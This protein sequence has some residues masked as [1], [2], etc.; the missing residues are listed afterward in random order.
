MI[1][2]VARRPILNSELP[3]PSRSQGQSPIE[4]LAAIAADQTRTELRRGGPTH[5]PI[6]SRVVL[7]HSLRT[8][9]PVARRRGLARLRA[10][11]VVWSRNIK[12][13]QST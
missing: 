9:G 3:D 11:R 5:P 10:E 13:L 1:I 8:Q 2:N 4:C 12:S 7:I 6:R